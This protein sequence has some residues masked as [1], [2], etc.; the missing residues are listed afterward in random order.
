MHVVLPSSYHF[1]KTPARL[2]CT[3]VFLGL[4]N[5]VRNLDLDLG[6]PMGPR[7]GG[8][9]VAIEFFSTVVWR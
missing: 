8:M 2:A 5:P 9:R 1:Q 7:P 4:E 6:L 3:L